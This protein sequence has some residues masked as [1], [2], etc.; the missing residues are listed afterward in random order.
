MK[1]NVVVKV[2]AGV[3]YEVHVFEDVGKAENKADELRNSSDYDETED[4]VDLTYDVE[5]N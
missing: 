5:V 3:V 4:C 1:V 2:H